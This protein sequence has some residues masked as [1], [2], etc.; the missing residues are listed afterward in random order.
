MWEGSGAFPLPPAETA[1]PLLIIWLVVIFVAQLLTLKYVWQRPTLCTLAPALRVQAEIAQAHAEGLTYAAWLRLHEYESDSDARTDSDSGSDEQGNHGAPPGT[2]PPSTPLLEEEEGPTPLPSW[3]LSPYE[4]MDSASAPRATQGG[5]LGR[6]SAPTTNAQSPS[7]SAAH[8]SSVSGK[9][10]L[11]TSHL[12][13]APVN[14]SPLPAHP[15]ADNAWHSISITSGNG[16]IVSLTSEHSELPR[17]QTT[18]P[19]AGGGGGVLAR[20]SS[21]VAGDTAVHTS[22]IPLH[23]NTTAPEQRSFAV[24]SPMSSVPAGGGATPMYRTNSGASGSSFR[25]GVGMSG[26]ERGSGSSSPHR[27]RRSRATSTASR[28]S[29]SPRASG[30]VPTSGSKGGVFMFPGLGSVLTRAAPSSSAHSGRS[31]ARSGQRS[32]GRRHSAAKPRDHTGP[33]GALP[34]GGKSMRRLRTHSRG[35]LPPST[36][37]GFDLSDPRAGTGLL[38]GQGGS[39]GGSSPPLRPQRA[40]SEVGQGGHL[41]LDPLRARAS[42]HLD[43]SAPLP[44]GGAVGGDFDAYH[45]TA[46][47]TADSPT[48]SAMVSTSPHS[49]NLR[50]HGTGGPMQLVLGGGHPRASGTI[51]DGSDQASG[52][53]PQGGTRPDETHKHHSSSSSGMGHGA[54]GDSTV[55]SSH[56][57]VLAPRSAAVGVAGGGIAGQ[58]RQ[59]VQSWG[60]AQLQERSADTAVSRGG[61]RRTRGA[62]GSTLDSVHLGEGGGGNSAFEEDMDEEA[63]ELAQAYVEGD[64]G[65]RPRCRLD[66]AVLGGRL[67]HRVSRCG[68]ANLKQWRNWVTI[69]TYLLEPVQF[70]GIVIVGS[71][72]LLDAVADSAGGSKAATVFRNLVQIGQLLMT[73][74]ERFSVLVTLCLVYMHLCGLLI[75][76]ELQPDHPMGPLLFQFM[77]GALY[78]TVT[79]SLLGLLFTVS[80]SALHILVAE[81]LVFYTATSVFVSIYRGDMTGQP[82]GLKTVPL[83]LGIERVLKGALAVLAVVLS[84]SATLQAA[85]LFIVFSVYAVLAAYMLPCTAPVLNVFRLGSA[86]IGVFGSA[87]RLAGHSSGMHAN[88]IFIVLWVG[89]A[90]IALLTAT[91]MLGMPGV[92]SPTTASYARGMMCPQRDSKPLPPPLRPISISTSPPPD[93]DAGGK[94]GGVQHVV[95]PMPATSHQAH[96][97]VEQ[98]SEQQSGDGRVQP[99]EPMDRMLSGGLKST[100]IEAHLPIP[101]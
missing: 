28:S 64:E 49:P 33:R 60:V 7:G 18:P 4:S 6:P 67:G 46:D 71:S 78:V 82:G 85:L 31:S 97:S 73:P 55:G 11:P 63:A 38:S 14:I 77:S 51:S 21:D 58:E 36:S 54:G 94:R 75:A 87:A 79:S 45:A 24:R 56:S 65:T 35:H 69:S 37:T 68:G 62:A 43:S 2:A 50:P 20:A 10:S 83:F 96:H 53:L 57:P 86:G 90:A 34:R 80:D 12:A 13:A 23:R 40:H 92:G 29:R 47:S 84:D 1:N 66:C 59:P 16:G 88:D 61:R 9:V 32:G 81:A 100:S 3:E 44:P 70:V 26:Q 48:G 98:H 15:K 19:A 76:L 30:H 22:G 52:K 95:L 25:S 41:G 27:R 42:S 8:G 39:Y 99:N 17:G 5:A 72:A 74:L 89:W 101:Q 93:G 91:I